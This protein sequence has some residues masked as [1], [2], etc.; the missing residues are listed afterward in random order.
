M[1][2]WLH[3]TMGHMRYSLARKGHPLSSGEGVAARRFRLRVRVSARPTALPPSRKAPVLNAGVVRGSAL[4]DEKLL[5]ELRENQPA[6]RTPT[7]RPTPSRLEVNAPIPARTDREHLNMLVSSDTWLHDFFGRVRLEHRK[8][9]VEL[10]RL[11]SGVLQML[12][13]HD[14]TRP[15]GRVVSLNLEL[16]A[17]YGRVEFGQ[18]PR[19]Q[20]VLTEINEGLRSGIS[21]GFL[22][23]ESRFLQR[24][25]AGYD[26]NRIDTIVSK[27][28]LHE[29]S[30]VTSP[31]NHLAKVISG[32]NVMTI[33]TMPNAATLT[34]LDGLSLIAAR[35]ALE[36]GTGSPSQR[37]KL[38]RFFNAFDD[39]LAN[40]FSRSAAITQAKG[41][42]GIS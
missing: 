11:H 29:I 27:W 7:P 17:L 12:A 8:E 2:D 37:A 6:R 24:G 16:D 1:A 18:T 26:E 32:G 20:A 41:E 13:D 31:R 40:G 4:H 39:A 15:V 42:S 25:E 14:S 22:V 30:S 35:R 3:G 38:T 10:R 28:E 5:S 21:P 23:L 36:L 9:S 34:D 19:A 33:T